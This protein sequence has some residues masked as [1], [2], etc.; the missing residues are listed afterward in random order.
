MFMKF[1]KVL[2]TQN[3]LLTDSIDSQETAGV[4]LLSGVCVVNQLQPQNLSL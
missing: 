2:F 1:A 4:Q 3:V